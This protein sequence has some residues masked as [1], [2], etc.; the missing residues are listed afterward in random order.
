MASPFRPDVEC[1]YIMDIFGSLAGE[2]E[3]EPI[4]LE[5]DSSSSDEINCGNIDGID[6][7]L[8]IE[9][10][11][12][13][14]VSPFNAGPKF[15]ETEDAIICSDDEVVKNSQFWDTVS[16]FIADFNCGNIGEVAK[17]VMLVVISASGAEVKFGDIGECMG[18]WLFMTSFLAVLKCGSSDNDLDIL[19]DELV[20]ESIWLTERPSDS[21]GLKCANDDK[22][23]FCR[24]KE[25][26]IWLAVVF[27]SIADLKL[28]DTENDVGCVDSELVR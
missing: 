12:L 19:D 14:V 4:W 16:S 11:C 22:I 9:F 7:N 20:K 10:T 18:S 24:D 8:V 1:G 17:D 28:G 23:M 6:V 27:S 2:A 5:R 25:R 21:A 26:A 13:E 15:G 3:K